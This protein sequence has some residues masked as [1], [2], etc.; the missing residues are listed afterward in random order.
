MTLV[1]HSGYE[2]CG[3]G[4][5][6][7]GPLLLTGNVRLQQSPMWHFDTFSME[8]ANISLATQSDA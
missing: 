1:L 4:H 3:Q 2:L 5:V 8:A 6:R 7:A